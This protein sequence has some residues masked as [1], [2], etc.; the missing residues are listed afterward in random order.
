MNLNLIGFTK[1]MW[2]SAYV[3]GLAYRERIVLRKNLVDHI[4]LK[5]LKSPPKAFN[6]DAIIIPLKFLL[7]TSQLTTKSVYIY[8]L[9]KKLEVTLVKEELF[10]KERKGS[11]TDNSLVSLLGETS[12]TSQLVCTTLSK[13]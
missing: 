4:V 13:I 7:A 9:L 1:S 2:Y 8:T 3:P 11:V 10:Y 5:S 12:C 6:E